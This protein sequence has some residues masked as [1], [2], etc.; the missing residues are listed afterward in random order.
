MSGT[1]SF[2]DAEL[3][4][5]APGERR[6]L[7]R[8]RAQAA[9]LFDYLRDGR[10][11]LQGTVSIEGMLDEAPLQG[12]LWIWPHRR[13]VRYEISF[14]VDEPHQ[15]IHLVGQK[16]VRLLDFRH[17]MSTLPA[18]LHD[19]HGNEVGCATVAF[20][21]ADLPAFLSSFRPLP[22]GSTRFA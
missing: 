3:G 22:V 4:K 8:L 2:T 15:R 14:P 6:I 11:V 12:S 7:L 1:V 9:S 18:T 10:T 16:D 20:D 17:T 5:S 13:I 21:W 19:E